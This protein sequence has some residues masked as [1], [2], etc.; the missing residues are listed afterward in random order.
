MKFPNS[1]FIL[2]NDMFADKTAFHR[3]VKKKMAILS[4]F[5]E[6]VAQESPIR[7][8]LPGWF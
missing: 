1:E 5:Q 6:L 8:Y 7:N 4:G 2:K 3:P